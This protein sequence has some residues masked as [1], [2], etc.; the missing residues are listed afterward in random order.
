[1]GVF[2]YRAAISPYKKEKD[3]RVWESQS[4]RK[5]LEE[6]RS[7]YGTGMTGS[8]YKTSKVEPPPKDIQPSDELVK[9]LRRRGFEFS[10]S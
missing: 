4:A 9:M 10:H 8:G 5:A 3:T 1:M 2:S 7:T 6:M